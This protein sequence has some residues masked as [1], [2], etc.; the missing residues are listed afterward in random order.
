MASVNRYARVRQAQLTPHNH[1][2]V[3]LC[4]HRTTCIIIAILIV[5]CLLINLHIPFLFEIDNGECYA[6]PGLYR[7]LFDIFFFIFYGLCPIIIMVIINVA[8][9][10]GIRRIRR[11]VHPTVSRGELYFIGLVIAHSIFNAVLTLPYVI[12]KFVY[13]IFPSVSSTQAAKLA[14]TI[15]HLAFFMNHGVSFFL[16]TLTTTAFRRELIQA[17]SDFLAR[18]NIKDIGKSIVNRCRQH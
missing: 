6:R 11:I 3:L 13:H 15:V 9:V 7:Y 2:Y 10:A 5:V 8:T 12:N 17:F 16:Y 4:E 1:C 14:G 18:I